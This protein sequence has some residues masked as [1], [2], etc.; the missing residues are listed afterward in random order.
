MTHLL[1]LRR[2]Y[3]SKDDA[4]F[5][6]AAKVETLLLGG[7]SIYTGFSQST[8]LNLCAKRLGLRWLSVA[9]L[10]LCVAIPSL[11]LAVLFSRVIDTHVYVHKRESIPFLY[12]CHCI[13][14]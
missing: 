2:I 10:I 5:Q 7:L 1:N 14:A 4:L 9:L 11:A 6:K 12:H 8:A 3:E 13:Y